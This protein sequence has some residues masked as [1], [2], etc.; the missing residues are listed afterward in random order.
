MPPRQADPPPTIYVLAG[1]NGA[2]KSSV[3]GSSIRESGGEYYNPDE[4]AR[5]LMLRR[6]GMTQTEA[7]AAAWQ[8]GRR[9]LEK[10]IASRK[11][12]AFETT[13]GAATI[14]RLL[15]EAAN[16][17]FAVRVRFVGL[18]TPEHHIAR[19]AARVA[20]GGHAIDEADIRR[21]FEH[22]RL[23]LIAL[24][25][26]LESLRLYDN[27]VSAAPAEGQAPHLRLVL[28]MEDK[29]ILNP[30]DL[31]TCPVWAKPIAASAMKL[32]RL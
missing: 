2:G 1:V 27:T 24:L 30:E 32:G 16:Q 4:V 22:S 9:L 26:V 15:A 3:L 10:A 12:Y 7:N 11:D 14:P 20:L 28:H 31:K 8:H 17:G 19:V 5:S 18:A 23:N 29:R 6:P 25:P 21:R 13:L